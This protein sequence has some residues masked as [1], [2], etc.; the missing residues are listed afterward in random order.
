MAVR[1]VGIRRTWSHKIDMP[2]CGIEMSWP[3]LLET[4]HPYFLWLKQ[5]PGSQQNQRCIMAAM[6]VPR[7]VERGGSCIFLSSDP[8]GDQLK[9]MLQHGEKNAPILWKAKGCENQNALFATDGVYYD[10]EDE[11]AYAR[12]FYAQRRNW[13]MYEWQFCLSTTS[14][15]LQQVQHFSRVRPKVIVWG[16]TPK[17]PSDGALIRP[18]PSRAEAGATTSVATVAQNLGVDLCTER[19]LRDAIRKEADPGRFTKFLPVQTKVSRPPAPPAGG[20]ISGATAPRPGPGPGSSS[21]TSQAVRPEAEHNRSTKQPRAQADTNSRPHPSDAA[22]TRQKH[23]S[24]TP[25]SGSHT[26]SCGPTCNL[27]HCHQEHVNGTATEK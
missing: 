25:A 3:V 1:D 20:S 12:N 27:Q 11:T 21:V 22:P 9:G 23:Q 8:R 19:E 7:D 6:F 5:Q 17:T 2:S 18:S 10:F 4:I 24:G 26:G 15:Y 13:T 16:C 14:G